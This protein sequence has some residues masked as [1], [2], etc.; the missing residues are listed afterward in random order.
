MSR[1]AAGLESV[2]VLELRPLQPFTRQGLTNAL[3]VLGFVSIYGLV[4]VTEEGFG[5]QAL[6]LGPAVLLVAVAALLLPLRGVH[7]RILQAKEAELAWVD[8]RILD[9]RASLKDDSSATNPG[10]LADLAAYRSLVHGVR[11]WPIGS[12]SYVRFALY[13]LIP[14]LSWAAAARV[15]R[16]VNP[17]IS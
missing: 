4:L 5:L 14:L 11:D 9:Q 16:V 15:E 13:L 8:T 10:T 3:L 7:A 6:V 12:S 17:L 1:L 2:D